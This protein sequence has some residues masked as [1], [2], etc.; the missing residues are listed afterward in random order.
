[1]SGVYIGVS[2]KEW[3]QC[4]AGRHGPFST[5]YWRDDPVTRYTEDTRCVGTSTVLS[6]Y[7]KLEQSQH[8]D[9][10]ESQRSWYEELCRSISHVRL[11][12][13][14]RGYHLARQLQT[15]NYTGANWEHV[16]V[17]RDESCCFYW[18]CAD[19]VKTDRLVK[20]HV[21]HHLR[22]FGG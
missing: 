17:Q 12:I 7:A 4:N 11:V 3:H 14:H 2:F 20:P 6:K 18:V 9:S 19:K 13:W 5:L 10:M 15:A 21:S 8:I 16:N 22:V 1:M